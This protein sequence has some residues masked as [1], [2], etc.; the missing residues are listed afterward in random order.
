MAGRVSVDELSPTGETALLERGDRPDGLGPPRYEFRCWPED[1]AEDLLARLHA[2]WQRLERDRRNDLY[3][4]PDTESA[5]WLIK[6]RDGRLFD[7]K[8]LRGT[9][10]RLELWQ[11]ALQAAFPLSD[12]VAEEVTAL[13]AVPPSR[14]ASLRQSAAHLTAVLA[15]GGVHRLMPVAKRRQHFRI[16]SCYAEFASI[17]LAGAEMISL[18][19]ESVEAERVRAACAALDLGGYANSNYG[20]MLRAAQSSGATP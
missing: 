18:C 7:I 8:V 4:L 13:F 2:G 17:Q 12:A 16:G 9:D 6:L 5:P 11:P 20:A 3:L 15:Q 1:R 19:V 10:D 14:E